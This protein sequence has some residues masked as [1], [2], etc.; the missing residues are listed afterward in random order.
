MVR[1]RVGYSGGA[2]INPTYRQLGDHTETI[3]IDFDPTLI[4]Y[5]ELLAV[6]WAGH[7]PGARPWSR[8]YLAAVFFHSEAQKRLSLETK[9]QMAAKIRGE[10]AT[11]ILPATEFYLAEDYHQ[12]YFLRRDL[13]LLKELTAIYPAVKDFAASTAAARLNGYVAGYGS[14]AGLARELSSLGLSPAGSA[15]LLAL[16]SRLEPAGPTP[17]CPLPR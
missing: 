13:Q 12:K 2:T 5:R 16:V 9:E 7:H 10:V 11:Q 3:Q 8:Q 4:S 1:T 17:G 15:R 6:F 14:R